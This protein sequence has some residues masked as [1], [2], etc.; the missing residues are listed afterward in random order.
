MYLRDQRSFGRW[1]ASAFVGGAL[2]LCGILLRR[3]ARGQ[4][5]NVSTDLTDAHRLAA[6]DSPST[7]DKRP[8][9]AVAAKWF[10]AVV[11]TGAVATLGL[12]VRAQY[13]QTSPGLMD[14]PDNGLVFLFFD[15]PNVRALLRVNVESRGVQDRADKFGVDSYD[16][17]IWV[18]DMDPKTSLTYTLV[19]SG[20]SRLS[21]QYPTGAPIELSSSGCPK[22]SVYNDDVRC[23]TTR[24][25]PDAVVASDDV[26]TDLDLIVGRVETP[27]V[28]E[29]HASP[30]LVQFQSRGRAMALQGEK[31]FF[32]LPQ[33]G[34]S[35]SLGLPKE[36]PP[37]IDEP[38]ERYPADLDL[39]VTY[40][41]LHP[42]ESLEGADPIPESRTPLTW[43][44]STRSSLAPTGV[45]T[46][47]RVERDNTR[48]V[49]MI[50]VFAGVVAGL[51]P[52][53]LGR[54]GT[55]FSVSGR[56]L[57]TWSRRR[58]TSGSNP[59]ERQD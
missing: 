50:G 11:L 17:Y 31:R 41:Q 45:I 19:L 34:T 23:S 15:R 48:R 57:Q 26:K 2:V 13:D 49:F 3:H 44:S 6:E 4:S 5:R 28:G 33:I 10:T 59:E 53:L 29:G 8:T 38:G 24:G 43:R 37:V 12:G 52:P 25:A 36:L 46:D 20:S 51:V 32:A 47:S 21:R 42:Y 18:Y 30:T 54:W 1:S 55:A 39:M 14:E 56:A 40:Q 7:R 9:R 27:L 22:A 35:V 16:A 58:R